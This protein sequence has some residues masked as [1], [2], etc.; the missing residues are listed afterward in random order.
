M[1][2]ISKDTKMNIF[3]YIVNSFFPPKCI[4]CDRLLGIDAELHICT[5]CFLKI[6]FIPYATFDRYKSTQHYYD[7]VACVC[8]YYG[9][10]K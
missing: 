9:I 4:F 10:V 8:K 3:E 2:D 1:F 7:K 5:E 6:N